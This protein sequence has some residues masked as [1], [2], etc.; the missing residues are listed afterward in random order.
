[1]PS[2]QEYFSDAHIAKSRTLSAVNVYTVR[3]P[4]TA[5]AMLPVPAT[6]Q[7]VGTENVTS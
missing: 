3:S 7:P 2:V 1:M 6:S 5:A 4:S